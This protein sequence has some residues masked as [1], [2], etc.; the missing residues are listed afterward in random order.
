M[1][2]PELLNFFNKKDLQQIALL[3]HY[4]FNLVSVK[5]IYKLLLQVDS[6]DTTLY[7]LMCHKD[8]DR[9][10]DAIVYDYLHYKDNKEK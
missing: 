8:S 2:F 9:T 3:I 10:L 7:L 4:Y 5:R 1:Y 6:I